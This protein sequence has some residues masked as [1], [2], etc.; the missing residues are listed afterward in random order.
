MPQIKIDA[1]TFEAATRQAFADGY[2]DVDHYVADL[3]AEAT[4]ALPDDLDPFFTPARVAEIEQIAAAMRAGGQ[5]FTTAEIR[6]EFQT[7]RLARQA[8]SGS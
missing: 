8:E 7:K 5:T 4:A 1:Q 2:K 6:Q 3:L